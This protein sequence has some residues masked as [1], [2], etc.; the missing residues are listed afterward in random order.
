MDEKVDIL[1]PPLFEPSGQIKTRRQANHDGDWIGSF[2]LWIVSPKPEPCIIYQQRSPQSTWGPNLL[3]V[4]VG[5]HLQAGEGLDGGL[6]EAR[7]EIGRLYEPKQLKFLGKTLYVGFN[8]DGS[9]HNEAIDVYLTEDS[10]T[11]ADYVLQPEEL[12]AIFACPISQLLS[13]HR[14]ANYSFVAHGLL[15]NG[16]PTEYSVNQQS[17]PQNYS[18]YHFKMALLADRYFKGEKDLLY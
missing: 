7:E 4:A 14:N 11:L 18:K 6:R 2:N 3:D 17:F 5:G 13:V 9:G 15:A 12:Y 16:E 1:L 8:L 10:S